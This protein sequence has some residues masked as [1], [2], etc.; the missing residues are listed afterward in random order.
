MALEQR[1][2]RTWLDDTRVAVW[3]LGKSGVAAAQLL[4]R[5]GYDVVASDTRDEASL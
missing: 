4:A 3:G 2:K 1:I 5:R